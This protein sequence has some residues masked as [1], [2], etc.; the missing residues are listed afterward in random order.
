MVLNNEWHNTYGFHCKC[1]IKNEL[2]FVITWMYITGFNNNL[3]Y[4]IVDNNN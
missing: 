1:H 3:V 2:G 4:K